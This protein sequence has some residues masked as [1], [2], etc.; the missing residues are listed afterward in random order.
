MGIIKKFAIH[1][2]F[3]QPLRKDPWLN[4]VFEETPNPSYSNFN[5]LITDECYGP[6]GIKDIK[7]DREYFVSAYSLINYDI[8]PSLLNYI[9]ENFPKLY[10]SI[11]ESDIISSKLFGYGNAIAHPYVHAI[12]PHLNLYQKKLYIKWGVNYFEKKFNRKPSGIWL[13]ET[14]VDYETL[15]VLIESGFKFTILSPSQIKSIKR[16]NADETLIN[17]GEID[18]T[19]PYLWVSKSNP[20][21]SITI[22]LYDQHLSSKIISESSNTEKFT[23]RIKSSL[24]KSGKKNGFSLLASDG[25]NWGHH[26][27]DGDKC[28]KKLLHHILS[29]KKEISIS[30]LSLLNETFK[31]EFEV[32]IISPSS[33]SCPHGVGR[34]QEDCGC[35]INPSNTYQKWRKTL[36][37]SVDSIAQ[38]SHE[39]FVKETISKIS[40]PLKA[41]EDY[42]IPYEDKSP[43]LFLEFIEKHAENKI[44]P[45]E[46]PL[47]LSLFESQIHLALSYTSC[48]WFF[49][50]ISGIE[51]LNNIKHLIWLSDFTKNYG[52]D[53]DRYIK[54]LSMEKSN[55]KINLDE[56]ILKLKKLSNSQKISVMEFAV[57]DYIGY[58]NPFYKT[59]YRFKII[60]KTGKL[61]NIY[62]IKSD[63]II[64]LKEEL[65]TVCLLD[66]NGC[67]ISRIKKT[68]D[69]EKEVENIQSNNFTGFEPFN[70]SDFNIETANLLSI[71]FSKKQSDLTLKQF[72]YLILSFDHTDEKIKIIKQNFLNLFSK[73]L[74]TNMHIP[75]LYEIAKLIINNIETFD[76]V[77]KK[78]IEAIKNL[79][80]EKLLWKL[81]IGKTNDIKANLY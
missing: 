6:L 55:F 39:V 79:G 33:W 48:G 43:H 16:H 29:L 31:P 50:D 2:H 11:I 62:L 73:K 8:A 81:N 9:E 35:R 4:P 76:E 72:Y 26:L 14:A 38:K 77:D 40:N 46:I 28:L 3:Y 67:F 69:F 65:W 45:K 52:I 74:E 23:L 44:L 49:D 32:D 58:T 22:F 75:F 66:E 1:A 21:K 68:E 5:Q 10:I 36:K 71:L 30:N 63:D 51:A 27:K 42:V 78:V 61:H 37:E 25:E 60:K 12:F 15:E 57:F 54:N 56:I 47:I 64:T 53:T 70:L 80:L 7:F 41:L 17:N 18:T 20:S 19:I 24:D 34:W 59:R 13:P